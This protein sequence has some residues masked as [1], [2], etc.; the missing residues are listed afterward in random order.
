MSSSHCCHLAHFVSSACSLLTFGC[1]LRSPFLL[2]GLRLRRWHQL[3]PYSFHH[4]YTLRPDFSGVPTFRLLG[5]HIRSALDLANLIM[6]LFQPPIYPSTS[7]LL[8]P[9]HSS[10]WTTARY[11]IFRIVTKHAAAHTSL[12]LSAD[13]PLHTL[14][15]LFLE[16]EFCETLTHGH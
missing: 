4:L 2:I 5:A 16:F 14:S 1:H 15:N 6:S 12:Y 7:G 10:D 8:H 13:F 11:F 3:I 9:P